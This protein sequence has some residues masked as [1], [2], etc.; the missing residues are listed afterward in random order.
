V[1][2]QHRRQGRLVDLHDHAGV[3]QPGAYVGD[4][5]GEAFGQRGGQ[6]PDG[7]RIAQQST[8]D[9]QVDRRGERPRTSDLHLDGTVEA[10]GRLGQ[11]IEV[12][13]PQI[14]GAPQVPAGV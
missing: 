14:T 9:R 8:A 1:T 13:V 2:G 10:G 3:R 12:A 7:A 4:V 6:I 11:R 5:Y